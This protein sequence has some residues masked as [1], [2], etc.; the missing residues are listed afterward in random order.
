MVTFH[1]YMDYNEEL[2]MLLLF[3]IHNFIF[4]S[5]ITR[6]LPTST[7]HHWLKGFYGCSNEGSGLLRSEKNFLTC[8]EAC[9][10]G[11]IQSC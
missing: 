11:K 6:T 4:V 1:I 2:L 3:I 8:V 10:A 9:L 5:R 7:K